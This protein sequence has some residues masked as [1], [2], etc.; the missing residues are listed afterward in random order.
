MHMEKTVHHEMTE[1]PRCGNRHLKQRREIAKLILDFDGTTRF[2][3]LT[4]HKGH[5]MRC[6][7]CRRT[8]KPKFPSIEGTAFGIGVLGYILEYA[9]K[10]NTDGDIAYYLKVFNKYKRGATTIWNARKALG[11]ML[12]PTLRLIIDELKKAPFLM[13]DETPYPY[14]KKKAYVWVVRTDTATLV[15]P[16]PGRGALCAPSFLHELRHMPVVVDGYV[17]YDGLFAV[18]QRC[19]AHILLNSEEAYIRCDDPA[20]KEVRKELH[21]RLCNMHRRA[22]KIAA[23][24]AQSGGANVYTCLEL[25]RE[26]AGIVAA[27]GGA[28]FAGHLEN[29][30]AHL[31]TFLRH[32]G[33]PSTNNKTEQDIR[34]A[35]V[36]QRKFRQKFVTA[37]GNAG[38]LH[39]DELPPHLP[40][41]ERDSERDV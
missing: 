41:A 9:G 12:A 14:K 13:I 11:A 33:M 26:V 34:D 31:F 5:C 10:K 38:I 37:G 23:D 15:V 8:Y 3:I 18:I 29:A 35:V 28:K 7:N 36:I 24:T 2:L 22:K 16:A 21:H 4:L 27:Y 40:Q 6:D 30:M 1:C 19:W 25:E 17:V 39:T 20:A 32:P